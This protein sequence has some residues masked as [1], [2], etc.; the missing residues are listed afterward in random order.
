MYLKKYL[1]LVVMLAAGI[2][3]V[4]YPN[5]G[6]ANS[7]SGKTLSDGPLLQ[8]PPAKTKKITVTL[9]KDPN[10]QCCARWATHMKENDF[11]VDVHFTNKLNEIKDQN[12]VPMNLRACHT[13]LVEGYVIEGHVPAEAIRKLLKDRPKKAGLAVAGMPAG[14][15]GTMGP[16]NV[17]YEVH[18]FGKEGSQSLYGTYQS[19]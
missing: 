4:I 16:R 12:K 5:S 9:F 19:H 13:A 1:F 17:P 11:T 8:N 14:A 6:N 7:L 18:L 10:C 3:L 15:P 2:S